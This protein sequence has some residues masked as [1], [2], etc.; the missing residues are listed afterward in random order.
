MT[1]RRIN[2]VS[3]KQYITTAE[4]FIKIGF[5]NADLIS[6]DVR[7]T[8]GFFRILG[9]P[10]RE[11]FTLH[12]W[13]DFVHPDDQ[14]EFR[15][16]S[17]L[18]SVGVSVSRE[19]RLLQSLHPSRWVRLV[20]EQYDE[21]GRLTGF[22]ED[23]SSEREA[24]ATV[25]RERARFN[26]L[27]GTSGDVVIWAVDRTGTFFNLKG[28]EKITGQFPK[29]GRHDCWLNQIHPD[30]RQVIKIAWDEYLSGGTP[31]E[32]IC[33][34]EYADGICRRVK[35]CG[36]P[37][38]QEGGKPTEWLGVVKELWRWEEL[39]QHRRTVKPTQ[40]RAARAMLGW[41]SD[42]LAREANVSPATIRRY[43]STDEHMKDSTIAVILAVFERH[44]VVMT[45]S[46]GGLGVMFA[47]QALVEVLESCKYP[48]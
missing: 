31:F 45:H 13:S 38:G 7:G 15:S 4:R 41:S 5:W 24:K 29:Q 16:I 6:G 32:C 25:Y 17:S 33:R 18:T 43:E 12:D 47:T 37:I 34:L 39:E 3:S 40:L 10:Q 11:G 9:L 46:P 48:G 19:I 28:W 2:L 23:I 27:V 8:D 22:I 42:K 1:D 14:E 30:D 44:G 35:F 36:T 20:A 26:A 21:M